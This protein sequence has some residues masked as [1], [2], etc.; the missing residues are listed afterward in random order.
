MKQRPQPPKPTEDPLGY[1]GV[2]HL[3]FFRHYETFFKIFWIAP[4]G[5][6][7]N[8]ETEWMQKSQ[9]KWSPLLHFSAAPFLHQD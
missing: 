4:K 6:P 3:E 1:L 8:F 5:P 2:F 7:F 9:P